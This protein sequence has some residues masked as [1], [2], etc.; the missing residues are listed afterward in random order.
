MGNREDQIVLL[1]DQHI[2]IMVQKLIKTIKSAR[3]NNFH[4]VVVSEIIHGISN[5]FIMVIQAKF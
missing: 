4:E 1:E 5:T 3:K 2:F